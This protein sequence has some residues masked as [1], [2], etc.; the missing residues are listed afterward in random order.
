MDDIITYKKEF[1]Y[2]IN[3]IPLRFNFEKETLST[4]FIFN[5]IND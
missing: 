3:Y 2:A 5:A 1:D 4:S